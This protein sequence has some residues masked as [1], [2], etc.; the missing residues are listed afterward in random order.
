MKTRILGILIL[1]IA[2]SAFAQPALRLPEVS[3]AATAGQT[4]GITDIAINYHRPAVNNRKIFGGLV[5]YGTLWRAGANENTTISFSTPVKVEGKD[6]AAGTYALY[7]IP[8]QPQW[9]V[10][11]SKF[12]GDWGA[13]NYD[14]SEDA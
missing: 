10:V 2:V 13:Y 11:L 9:T 12:T 7:M 14:E 4:I 1:L 8:G 5:Q 3:P 6:V